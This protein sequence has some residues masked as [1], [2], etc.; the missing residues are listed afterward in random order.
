[1][2]YRFL[3]RRRARRIH[4]RLSRHPYVLPVLLIFS[5]LLIASG[6]FITLNS[7]TVGANDARIVILNADRKES[8]LPT[9]EE[10]VGSFLEKA[11]VKLNDGDVVEPSLDT[12]IQEDN[13]RI[14]VY[15]AAPVVV[16]D[17]GAKM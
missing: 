3:T 9:R 6:L 4:K 14:N 2:H 10:T 8:T 12:K 13:F 1:Y 17:G 11:E 5:A 15:R 7:H 16:I